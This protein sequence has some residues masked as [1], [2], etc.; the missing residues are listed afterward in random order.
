AVL[1]ALFQVDGSG[2]RVPIICIEEPETGLHPGAMGVLLE[3]MREASHSSQLIVTSHSPD[4][5][6]DKDITADSIIAVQAENG[7]AQIGP[8]NEPS[9]S[10]LRDRLYTAGELLRHNQLSPEPPVA[11]RS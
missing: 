8:I 4:L 6:D 1:C 2:E 10:L 9:R 11:P 7:L 5:L 3:A